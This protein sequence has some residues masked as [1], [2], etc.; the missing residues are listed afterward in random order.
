MIVYNEI[1]PFTDD[2][3]AL[4]KKVGFFDLSVDQAHKSLNNALRVICAYDGERLAGMGRLIGDGALICY[5][6]DVMVDPEYQGR[7]IGKKIVKMLI[8][9]AEEMV[10]PGTRMYLGLMSVKGTEEFYERLGFIKRPN[11]RFGSGLTLVLKKEGI[12][13]TDG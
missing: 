5:I 4:R 3:M 12:T 11:D 10:L 6:Q 13:E 9:S 2:Y 1:K 7:G 8:D